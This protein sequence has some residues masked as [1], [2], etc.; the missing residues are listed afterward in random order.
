MDDETHANIWIEYSRCL[1]S[2]Y[3]YKESEEALEQ[4]RALL[5]L[6]VKLTGKMGRRSKYSQKSS[7]QLVL[8][9]ESEEV[10]IKPPEVDLVD[11]P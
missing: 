7:P 10:K 6:K 9:V 1:L 11:Q 4:A 2:F 3:K 8:D 5:K